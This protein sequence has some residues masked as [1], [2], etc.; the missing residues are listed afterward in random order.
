MIRDMK[1]GN[2]I[3]TLNGPGFAVSLRSSAGFASATLQRPIVKI[4][5]SKGDCV[6]VLEGHGEFQ[7]IL[8]FFNEQQLLAVSTESG[9]NIW[10]LKLGA[11]TEPIPAH[12]GFVYSIACSPDGLLI[13]SGSDDSIKIWETTNGTYIRSIDCGGAGLAFS[14]DGRYLV[15]R[16]A[17]R[18]WV[19]GFTHLTIWNADSGGVVKRFSDVK[20]WEAFSP[21]GRLLAFAFD[22]P[23]VMIWD[24][25]ASKKR[26]RIQ[27]RATCLI[28]SADGH[29][30]V[31]ASDTNLEIWDMASGKCTWT[32]EN[33]Q[34]GVTSIALSAD[35]QLLATV[36][37][38]GDIYVWN[39]GAAALRAILLPG[40]YGVG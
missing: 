2:C 23:I 37:S 38:R 31:L 5:N 33:R 15:S 21:D 29:K 12:A 30:L 7:G 4:W 17:T 39:I 34:Y 20:R 16:R 18:K 3:K 40:Q 14:P 25:N 10:D 32:V 19:T 22:K 36:T 28:F 8:A 6:Q 1:T 9:I 26:H 24:M 35:T 11:S 13:A 27:R